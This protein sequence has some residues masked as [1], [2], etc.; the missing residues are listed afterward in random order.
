MSPEGDTQDY[1]VVERGGRRTGKGTLQIWIDDIVIIVVVLARTTD[2]NQPAKKMLVFKIIWKYEAGTQDH[3][4][5]WGW[6]LSPSYVLVEDVGRHWFGC[7]I[8]VVDCPNQPTCFAHFDLCI[9]QLC[10]IIIPLA[11]E[12]DAGDYHRWYVSVEDEARHSRGSCK[13]DQK[14]KRSQRW[15]SS[16]SSQ[17]ERI[18][19][20]TKS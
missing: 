6:W 19:K 12:Y 15:T 13:G 16:L 5:I 3:M 14:S 11:N 1:Q 20:K 9:C 10:F 7:W 2:Q 18:S 17:S 4:R 8:Y